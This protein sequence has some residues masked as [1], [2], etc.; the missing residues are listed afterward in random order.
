MTEELFIRIMARLLQK[1]DLALEEKNL[2]E[3]DFTNGVVPGYPEVLAS[4]KSEILMVGLDV[5]HNVVDT[6]VDHT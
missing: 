4:I 6:N 2:I 5:Y 1:A 3:D